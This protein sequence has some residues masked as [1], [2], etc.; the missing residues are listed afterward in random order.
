MARNIRGGA[1]MRWI[2]FFFWIMLD[3][4]FIVLSNVIAVVQAAVVTMCQILH[5]GK[6]I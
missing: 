4:I 3:L 6:K 2:I 5:E 1:T